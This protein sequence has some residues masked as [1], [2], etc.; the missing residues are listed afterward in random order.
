MFRDE[1]AKDSPM[2]RWLIEAAKQGSS[3]ALG[4]LFD[5]N[6]LPVYRYAH[7]ALDDVGAAEDV[8]SAVFQ[9]VNE[10]IDDYR[11]ANGPFISWL[12][13]IARTEVQHV[14]AKN[15]GLALSV[16]GPSSGKYIED[17]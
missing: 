16:I 1:T 5:V 17:A 10:E 7:A 14:A 6:V 3:Q 11:P 4:T 13:G 12:M 8:T 15:Q 9:R 2:E